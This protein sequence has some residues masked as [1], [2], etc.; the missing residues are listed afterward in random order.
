MRRLLLIAAGIAVGVVVARQLAR[1]ARTYSPAGLA[2]AGRDSALGFLGSVRDF[3]ADVRD[4]MAEK[5]AEIHAAFDDGV[6]LDDD[7][8]YP[9]S[10]EDTHTRTSSNGA[11][12]R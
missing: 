4:G 11:A 8:H 2:G 7:L 9:P 10:E 5:E 12:S 6:A 3:V 1:A